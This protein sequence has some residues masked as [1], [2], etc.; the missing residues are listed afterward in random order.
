MVIEHWA[1]M[2]GDC[3]LKYPLFGCHDSSLWCLTA[4]RIWSNWGLDHRWRSVHLNKSLLKLFRNLLCSCFCV[5]WSYYPAG[6]LISSG[7][8]VHPYSQ[9]TCTG[10]H[11]LSDFQWHSLEFFF[12]DIP[13]YLLAFM[14]VVALCILFI[15][16]QLKKNLLIRQ[17]VKSDR[18]K[19]W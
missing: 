3:G 8:P 6:S 10:M 4:W 19:W 14:C 2:V 18:Y 15:N 7:L 12:P 11:L 13:V 17:A 1:L 9:P 5:L 16:H